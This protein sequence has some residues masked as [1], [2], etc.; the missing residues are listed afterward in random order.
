ML[1]IESVSRRRFVLDAS[2]AGAAAIFAAHGLA[3]GP[4]LARPGRRPREGE[5][6]IR[7]LRL[8][9][10]AP[11]KDM[12][13]FY[14]GCLGL[15]VLAESDAE[16]TIGAGATPITFERARD[17]E[18]RPLYHFAFNIPHNKILEARRWQLERSPLVPW[19]ARQRDK[20]IPHED[21]RHFRNWN[22][23][24]VFFFDPAMNIV[25]YIARH[26]L[27]NDAPGP[28]TPRDILYA[29]EIAFVV[30]DQHAAARHLGRAL[31]LGVY[32]PGER[33][34][35]AMGDESGLLLCVPVR[36]W[37]ATTDTPVTLEAFPVR[38]EIA[39]DVGRPDR[40]EFEGKPYEVV[41]ADA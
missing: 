23:H 3:T 24:S 31:G 8:Q 38:A 22:S 20:A 4:A 16:I 10:A 41:V 12:K 17:G 36:Q 18:G 34:W 13:A 7:A 30:D 29:S 21:V 27:K 2:C 35:W 14:H 15:D 32:P 37:G 9:T 25:E 33:F 40:Y 26:A 11:I 39:G 19:L 28:F 5:P 1:D 6:L